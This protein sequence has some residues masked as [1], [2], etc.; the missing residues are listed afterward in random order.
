MKSH[1]HIFK[2]QNK[3][4]KKN[5]YT[6]IRHPNANQMTQKKHSHANPPNLKRSSTKPNR[7]NAFRQVTSLSE[8]DQTQN[9]KTNRFDVD[10]LNHGSK[11]MQ[12][13]RW[14]QKLKIKTKNSNDD[15]IFI[16]RWVFLFTFHTDGRWWFGFTVHYMF[17]K[18]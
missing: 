17:V 16:C 5:I 2:P 9:I 4:S 15:E 11:P 13:N 8:A 3:N 18:R 12:T 14:R 1:L 7:F 6:P 10:F